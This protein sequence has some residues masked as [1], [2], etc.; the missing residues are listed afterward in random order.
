[1][2]D[3]RTIKRRIKSIKNTKQ[4]TKAMELVSAAKMRKAQSQVLASRPY[5]R[6][7]QQTLTNLATLIQSSGGNV[8][9][10]L[11]EQREIKK[12][13][14]IAFGPDK[15]LCGSLPINI[16]KTY[17][18]QIQSFSTREA[19]NV[20]T[21]GKKIVDFSVR[22][23]LPILADFVKIKDNPEFLDIAPLSKIILDDYASGKV[24]EVKLVYSQFV[25]TLTQQA[26]VKKILPISREE[27]FLEDIDSDLV[28]QEKV[29]QTK[30]YIFE[31]NPES[32]FALLLPY[33]VEM[34]IYQSLLESKA[35]EHS[36]RMVAM[37]S[38]TDKA[39][40]VIFDLTLSYNTARQS[41]ITREVAEI[42]AGAN[43]LQ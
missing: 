34:T 10:S 39:G 6:S 16:V 20:L 1:M 2:S 15:G 3:I 22:T 42:S 36:A 23:N 17:A 5:V 41:A 37:K 18:K 27:L 25:S 40:E 32:I 26:I 13:Y 21:V 19:Y 24:D 7:L 11:L 38:A 8:S 4:I 9:H 12:S 43:A 28:Q 31:P 30:D 14:I 33:F 29:S 35:S